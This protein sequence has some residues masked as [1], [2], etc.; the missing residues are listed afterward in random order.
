MSLQEIQQM[1]FK[2]YGLSFSNG[3]SWNAKEDLIFIGAGLIFAVVMW[4]G[5]F[6]AF[7]PSPCA[8]GMHY[9]A[10]VGACVD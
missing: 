5:M 1:I 4:Y 9:D 10:G 6:N 8:S 2:T 3:A 7:A